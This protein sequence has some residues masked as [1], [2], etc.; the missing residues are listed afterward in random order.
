MNCF[1][2][3]IYDDICWKNVYNTSNNY[4][5]RLIITKYKT[6]GENTWYI[7]K[8]LDFNGLYIDMIYNRTQWRHLIQV[9]NPPS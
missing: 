4:L 8:E 7:K 2:K 3:C 9:T 5:C 6:I 1:S